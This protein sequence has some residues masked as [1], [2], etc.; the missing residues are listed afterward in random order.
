MAVDLDTIRGLIKTRLE[1]I[2]GT[3]VAHK[4][5]PSNLNEADCPQWLIVPAEATHGRVER[6]GAPPFTG[7]HAT[8][9]TWRLILL[10]C[11]S[12]DMPYGD[13][14]SALDPFFERVEDEFTAH[15][16]LGS[17]DPQLLMAWLASDTGPAR[18]QF[19]PNSGLWW[20]G[21]EWKLNVRVN[22]Q[23]VATGV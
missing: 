18:F 6:Q 23:G 16:K 19:P 14:E 20:F 4:Y 3:T 15:I 17:S 1:N 12:S 10:L 21:C 13:D 11:K 8:V 22:R 5:V 7:G 2:T 9:R